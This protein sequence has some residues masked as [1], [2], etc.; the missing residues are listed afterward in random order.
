MLA[1]L[2]HD[3]KQA[4]Q[5]LCAIGDLLAPA[6]RDPVGA[7]KYYERAVA[8]DPSNANAWEALKKDAERAGDA[9]RI[10]YCLEQRAMH[11]EIPRVRAQLFVEVALYKK[12]LED[13]QGS[14]VAF[15][16]AVTADPTNEVAA[17][18]VLSSFIAAKRWAEAEPL[19]ELLVNA[20]TRDDD[21]D[22]VFELL[23]MATRIAIGLRNEDRAVQ[24]ALAAYEARPQA[25]IARDELLE[26]CHFVRTKPAIV[27]KAKSGIDQVARAPTLPID[28][29][30]RLADIYAALGDDAPALEALARV[31]AIQPQSRE[32]FGRMVDLHA[33]RGEWDKACASKVRL[34][35]ATPDPQQRYDL[36]VEAGDLWVKHH[37]NFVLAVKAYEEALPLRHDR[38]LLHKLLGIYGRMRS[39]EKLVGALRALADSEKDPARKAKEVFTMA[40]AVEKELHDPI[41]AAGLYEEAIGL[42]P[43]R[44]DSFDRVVRIYTAAGDWERLER[45]YRLMI[46]KIPQVDDPAASAQG[47]KWGALRHNLWQQLGSVY[48][49]R[50]GD[51]NR[52]IEAFR[53]A[54]ALEPD[55]VQGRQIVAELLVIAGRTEEAVLM[56]RTAIQRA[57]LEPEPYAELYDLF[58]RQRAF[59]KAWCALSVLAHFGSLTEEQA[60]FYRDYPPPYLHEVPGT[61][62]GDAWRSHVFH[63][64]LDRALTTIFSIMAPAV[65]RVRF[66][67][68]PPSRRKELLGEPIRPKGI[69][70]TP[71]QRAMEII[72]DAAEILSVP[73][74][75]LRLSR[76]PLPFV[77]APSGQAVLLVSPEAVGALSPE[78]LAFIAGKRLAEMR[79]E[80]LARA[81]FPT[82]TEL[83]AAAAAAVR[84]CRSPLEGAPPSVDLATQRLDAAIAAGMT[85]EQKDE[86]HR[87]VED[88]RQSGRTVDVR[89]WSQLVDATSTRAGLLL[90]GH[91]D[92]AKKAMLHEP[93]SPC[94]L[95]P[96]ERL[97]EM[98]VFATSEEYA[99]LRGAIG[100][101]VGSDGG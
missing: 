42:D 47:K 61:L 16:R 34:A 95:P 40:Q 2:A 54:R 99:D 33:R 52:A 87:A 85:P 71:I 67:A 4:G 20:A 45:A 8:M 15:E 41:R 25:S 62:L 9:Q 24:T 84:I 76:G 81:Y 66:A 53:A 65:A 50:L 6:D 80:L 28:A 89:R 46:A 90:C 31:L 98:L 17:N 82:V 39:W 5:I 91:V 11:A 83:K 97:G 101:A 48:R 60:R 73:A 3:E 10:G 86:L 37:K 75:E 29:L 13:E 49:D 94:D 1:A 14:L 26:I 36:L 7:R 23:R 19:C 63:L 72:R 51:V 79:P 78:G 12:K 32:A 18:A 74:P 92:I 100:I 56:T 58:L 38:K 30:L 93:Q 69:E 44:L 68:L 77:P 27:A 96:R 70:G 59:D 57:P 55:D 43:T 64:K 35:R 21:A 22:R 88:L